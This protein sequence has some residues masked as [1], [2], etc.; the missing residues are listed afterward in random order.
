MAPKILV[1]TNLNESGSGHEAF[2]A[3]KLTF[4]VIPDGRIGLIP[5]PRRAWVRRAPS[6]PYTSAAVVKSEGVKRVVNDTCEPVAPDKATDGTP[7]FAASHAA[8]LELSMN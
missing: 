8:P 3:G 4:S 1:S 6:S 5:D 7:S 2:T